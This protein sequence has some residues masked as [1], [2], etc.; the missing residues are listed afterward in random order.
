MAND[1]YPPAG[2]RRPEAEPDPIANTQAFRAFAG[3]PEPEVAASGS[4]NVLYIVVPVVI[5]VAIIV[6]LLLIR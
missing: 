1:E 4:R 5:V 2:Q 3:E 6:I